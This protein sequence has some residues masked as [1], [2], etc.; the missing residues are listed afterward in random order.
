MIARGVE[1][2]HQ[3]EFGYSPLMAAA[4]KN[5]SR[6]VLLLLR[7]NVTMLDDQDDDGKTAFSYAVSNHALDVVR[8]FEALNARVPHE[9]MDVL[10]TDPLCQ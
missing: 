9:E 6:I 3:D 2:F 8:I 7:R 5:N 4:E 1:V 10:D